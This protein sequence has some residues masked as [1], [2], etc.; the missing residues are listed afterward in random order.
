MN[1]IQYQLNDDVCLDVEFEFIAPCYP[2]YISHIYIMEITYQGEAYKL[3]AEEIEKLEQFIHKQ[4]R[5]NQA[6][7]EMNHAF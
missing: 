6:E 1:I 7:T 2:D 5:Q 3:T 4:Y